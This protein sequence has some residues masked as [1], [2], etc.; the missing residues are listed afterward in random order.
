MDIEEIR[1]INI[2]YWADT[3]GRDGLA[4]KCG[5][6]DA[7][8]VNQLCRGH[9]VFGKNTARKLEQSLNLQRGW[10]DVLHPETASD[11]RSTVKAKIDELPTDLLPKVESYIDNMLD[12][13]K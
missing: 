7:N 9:G 3:L 6:P 11:K 12:E 2:N 8:Y 13:Q 5:Y 4:Q 10:F 1:Q